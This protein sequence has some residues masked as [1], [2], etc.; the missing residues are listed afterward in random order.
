MTTSYTPTRIEVFR[1]DIG[2]EEID[3]VA[4]VLR[5]GWIGGGPKVAEFEDAWARH[6]G[7]TPEHVVSVGCATEALHQVALELAECY[8]VTRAVMPGNAFI[9]AP[10][11]ALAAGL[12]VE[13]CDIDRRTLNPGRRHVEQCMAPE[14]AIFYQ[15]YGG[16]HPVSLA[17]EFSQLCD[18]WDAPL[19]EDMACHPMGKPAGEF[20]IWSFDA[21]KVMSCGD[22]GMIYCKNIEAA[23]EIRRATRLGMDSES[24]HQSA[25]EAWWEFKASAPGRRSMMN[26][27]GAA[28]GLVQLGRL[29]QMV[30]RRE[31]AWGLY[32]YFLAG[33]DWLT[34]P[35]QPEMGVSGSYYTYWVQC[36]RRDELARHLRER[37]IYTTYRYWPVHRAY[38]WD[39][40]LP[41]VDWAA[42]R[43]LNLPLHPGLTVED[44]HF[45]C[46][47]IREF[48]LS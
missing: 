4:G 48:D 21:M 1:P 8:G 42:D 38:G 2:Q 19:V 32:E 26:D 47:A 28:I 25:A 18:L 45:I 5:S 36:D 12:T 15:H 17:R 23:A 27:I 24:G 37:G 41:G 7:T 34:L 3:A 9:G 11:A 43:T 6:I 44:I 20:A 22:G 16:F 13:L 39:A 46:A 31:S 33:Q 14:S 35:P 29:E 40:D 30:A 10:A